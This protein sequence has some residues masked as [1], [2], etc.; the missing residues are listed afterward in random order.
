MLLFFFINVISYL[1]ILKISYLYINLKMYY[2]FRVAE[3]LAFIINNVLALII[4]FFLF[5]IKV[6]FLIFFLNC[7]MSYIVYH[8]A[9]MIQTSPRTKILLDLYNN[10]INKDEYFK[11]YTTEVIL[12][13]RLKR[14]ITSKQIQNIDNYVTLNNNKNSFIKIV[15]NVFKII[16]YF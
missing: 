4:M 2:P 8:V 14:F 1:I 7:L 11:N 13:N 5:E 15:L 12:E 16:K 6:I 3:I 9:N 10:K